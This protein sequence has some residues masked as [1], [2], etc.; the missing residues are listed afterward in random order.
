MENVPLL[1]RP[2]VVAVV[3]TY[4]PEPKVIARLLDVL[5]PQVNSIVIVDNGSGSD[6]S[7]LGNLSNCATEVLYLRENRGIATAQN[8]GIQWARA[9]GAE[10][11]LLMDQDS[12]PAADMV[13]Q[14]SGAF[15]SL[16]ATGHKVACVGPFYS[17]SRHGDLSP[18]VRLERMRF[19]R[20]TC[21]SAA[22]FVPVDFVISSGCLIPLSVLDAVGGMQDDLFIDYVDIEWGL[23]AAR[24]GYQSYG[25]CAARMEHSLGGEPIKFFGR[26]FPSHSPLRGYY[27]FRNGILL[28]K[29][30][31]VR[32]MWKLTDVKRLLVLYAFFAILSKPR[33]DHLKMMSLGVWHGL[34]GK[35]GKFSGSES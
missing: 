30:P 18:F 21:G 1:P 12:E 33:L 10:F 16:R 34:I 27:R 13:A 9:R 22:A 5:A 23:R 29:Q 11:V 2:L 25:V 24:E 26:I 32:W 19:R 35:T 31:W 15:S 3:V 7:L 6:L 28:L 20:I 17:D 8:I 14:L 4:N